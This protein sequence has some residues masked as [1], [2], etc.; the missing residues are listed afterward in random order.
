MFATW[1]MNCLCFLTQCLTLNNPRY[2]FRVYSC[3]TINHS[4]FA[5]YLK[6]AAEDLQLIVICLQTMERESSRTA[7]ATLVAGVAMKL[8]RD[9]LRHLPTPDGS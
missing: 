7:T 3:A 1:K 4:T 5:K 6:V 9:W 2:K 8:T